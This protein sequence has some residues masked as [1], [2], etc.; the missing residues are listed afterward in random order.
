[1]SPILKDYLI[2]S[3]WGL[4][5]SLIMA[6]SLGILL[7]VF[8]WLTPINEWEEIKKGNIAVGI[9]IGAVAIAFAIVIA[10]AIAPTG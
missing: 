9:I 3:G 4:L 7:K 2:G 8:A 10:S 6:I 1:M 5:G